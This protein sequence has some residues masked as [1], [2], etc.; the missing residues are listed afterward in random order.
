MIQPEEDFNTWILIACS[1]IDDPEQFSYFI[2]DIQRMIYSIIDYHSLPP[3]ITNETVTF[4][5]RLN[6]DILF[7]SLSISRMS[8]DLIELFRDLF[9]TVLDFAKYGIMVRNEHIIKCG[10]TLIQNHGFPIFRISDELSSIVI[11]DYAFKIELYQLSYKELAN[12]PENIGIFAAYYHIIDELSMND[13]SFYLIDFSTICARAALKLARENPR[14]NTQAISRIFTRIL[15]DITHDNYDTSEIIEFCLPWL[16]LFC[17]FAKSGIFEKVLFGFQ[18]IKELFDD[19]KLVEGVIDYF[20]TP[21]NLKIFEF[22]TIHPEL[23]QYV[24][25]I[26][27]YLADY[28]FVPIELLT[29]LWNL[30]SVQH[31]SDLSKFLVIFSSIATTLSIAKLNILVPLCISPAKENESEEWI[32]FLFIFGRNVG[33]RTEAE[34]CFELIRDKLLTLSF[35]PGPFQL[36]IQNKLPAII[37][38]H[39]N[40]ESFNSIY[41]KLKEH[42]NENPFFIYSL[43]SAAFFSQHFENR[44]EAEELLNKTFENLESINDES[45]QNVILTFIGS[46][47]YN[48]LLELE[49]EQL[50]IIF[51]YKNSK[52]FV[53]LVSRLILRDLIPIDHLQR[54]ILHIPPE[55]INDQI[56][57]LV[58]TI[59]KFYN[60]LGQDF[61]IRKLP[62]IH[63]KL[64]WE[65]SLK[66][67][68]QTENFAEFLCKLYSSNDGINLSDYDMMST[69]IQTWNEYFFGSSDKDIAISLLRNFIH[70]IESTI[71]VESYNIKRHTISVNQ[72]MIHVEINSNLL[73]SNLA[74]DLPENTLVLVV[75]HRVA[76]VAFITVNEFIFL[77][78]N[79]VVEARATLRQIAGNQNSLKFNIKMIMKDKVRPNRYDRKVI[80]SQLI[81]QS[82][83]T[84]NYLV[85]LL[86]DNNKEAKLLLDFLPTNVDTLIHIDEM[87]KRKSFDYSS[88]LP[89]EF[90]NLF[91]YNFEALI[92]KFNENVNQ[93]KN[94]FRRTGGFHYLIKAILNEELST[95]VI[96][97]MKKEMD[98]FIKRELS[99][100]LFDVLLPHLIKI[101]DNTSQF[102]AIIE[103]LKPIFSLENLNIQLPN[104]FANDILKP[105]IFSKYSINRKTIPEFLSHLNIPLSMFI[106]FIEFVTEE[107]ADTFYKAIFPH[108][109]EKNDLLL[110]K[111]TDGINT[112]PSYLYSLLSCLDKMLENNFINEDDKIIFTKALINSYLF[113]DSQDKDKECFKIAVH[114]L[115]M[116]QN[117]ILLDHLNRLHFGRTQYSEWDIDGDSNIVS[118]NGHCGLSNLGATCF[119]NS[120]LQQF[121]S[122]PVLRK[123]VIE[124]NGNDQFMNQLRILF[125]E[126]Y[127]S[128]GQLQSP[129]KLVE[130][131]T[132]WDGEPMDPLIQQDAV[133]FT[134][135]LIDKLESGLTREFMNDIFG[136][137][138]LDKF[139]GISDHF[140]SQSEQSFSSF[141]LPIQGSSNVDEAFLKYQNPDFFT[142]ENQYFAESLNKKIDAKKY[143][144]LGKLPRVLIMQLSRFEYDYRLGN[145]TK[146]NSTFHFPSMLDLS[147]YTTNDINQEHIYSIHG[148]VMHHGAADFGHYTSYIKDKETN[149]WFLYNDSS[150][151]EVNEYEVLLN[152]SGQQRKN[153]SGYILFYERIDT[154]NEKIETPSISLSLSSRIQQE[155]H[156]KDEYRLFCSEPYYELMKM[157]AEKGDFH[158]VSIPIYYYFDTFP[159]TLHVKKANDFAPLIIEKL[160]KFKEL[161]VIFM[162]FLS[163][164]PFSCSLIYSSV[165]SVRK[166]ALDMIKTLEFEL[167]TPKFIDKLIGQINSLY[168]Y[169]F[170]QYFLLIYHLISNSKIIYDYIVNKNIQY[171]IT[172]LLFQNIPNSILENNDNID[173]FYRGIC[174]TGLFYVISKIKIYPNNI[175]FFLNEEFM[176]NV[177]KSRTTLDSVNALLKSFH[178]LNLSNEAFSYNNNDY[179]CGLSSHQQVSNFIMNLAGKY[180]IY[181]N[182]FRIIH[183]LFYYYQIDA[184]PLISRS[185]FVIEGRSSNNFDLAMAICMLIQQST[186]KNIFLDNLDSWLFQLLTDE[187]H[188]CRIAAEHAISFLVQD[189]LFDDIPL[190]PMHELEYCDSEFSLAKLSNFEM[191]ERNNSMIEIASAVHKCLLKNKN[192][193]IELLKKCTDLICYQYID[194]FDI[195]SEI[196]NYDISQDFA[197]IAQEG[198]IDSN[199]IKEFD[200]HLS[201]ICKALK[202]CKNSLYL[203]NEFIYQFFPLVEQLYNPSCTLTV[204]IKFFREMENSVTK[205][206]KPFIEVFLKQYT[207]DDNINILGKAKELKSYLPIFAEN[208]PDF[209]FEILK[210]N[211]FKFATVNLSDVIYLLTM[212]KPDRK[213]PL[214]NY[215]WGSVNKKQSYPLNEMVVLAFKYHLHQSKPNEQSN[216]CINEF[217]DDDIDDILAM[218]SLLNSP[219][220]HES[221]RKC[222]WK[223]IFDCKPTFIEFISVYNW[224]GDWK[225]L[226]IYLMIE[227]SPDCVDLAIEASRNSL[228]A[229]EILFEFLIENAPEKIMTLSFI[230]AIMTQTMNYN[231]DFVIHFIKSLCII[232]NSKNNLQNLPITNDCPIK[233]DECAVNKESCMKNI[234]NHKENILEYDNEFL[235][236][237]ITPLADDL[238]LRVKCFNDI[239]V[240]PIFEAIDGIGIQQIIEKMKVLKEFEIGKKLCFKDIDLL[241]KACNE[242]ICDNLNLPEMKELLCLVQEF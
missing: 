23:C 42:G 166:G 64:L 51:K 176:I 26:L 24:S 100:E 147:K 89:L 172:K 96:A 127:L 137:T 120:T 239:L 173:S 161:R 78:F 207:F 182:Y 112:H 9:F 8:D 150:V 220:L 116:M 65:M 60:E 38:Y 185:R 143:A 37:N 61:R 50:D 122:I 170:D 134:Q 192:K 119:L 18:Q 177:L 189:R 93:I 22:K 110:S 113:P 99:Q 11:A 41:F 223:L 160:R 165:V 81:M 175:H 34:S 178:T 154:I 240:D 39:L 204:A 136:G 129:N 76:R 10:F 152:G 215:I 219:E 72:K 236:R 224:K 205:F 97:F 225:D 144:I 179:G 54:I 105:L 12:G 88:F 218:I 158:F 187:L 153:S 35:T 146:I 114:C 31:S 241:K 157:L 211:I 141:T 49:N 145:R 15:G 123:A 6:N 33:E 130:V 162:D 83:E 40:R 3:P 188:D 104:N 44:S 92:E 91:M 7:K 55:E 180:G 191:I 95:K 14:M 77:R 118:S 171:F 159:F 212:I 131:W 231:H 69:F 238:C 79:K 58:S 74:F 90:P 216:E 168:Y 149:K 186:L 103:F 5:I 217:T 56:Y 17:F 226:A 242:K 156:K 201:R 67:S 199:N 16:D 222:V 229:F 43:L 121:F 27:T 82:S 214:L 48:N 181:N 196:I 117:N 151:S 29:S 80:P 94:H 200:S 126:M 45:S 124:Y 86:K 53:N 237:I 21:E 190:L 19:E 66:R 47:C 32:N 233:T 1:T 164:G 202:R 203:N 20:S 135:M 98:D 138:T 128:K 111:I 235:E 30:H 70:E 68:S 210:Q 169:E 63:E 183:L 125:A 73:S 221:G 163:E 2:P 108:I 46:L 59:V 208:E 184:I 206:P 102:I 115:S 198:I 132:G 36:L 87:K 28:D 227:K 109:Y 57:Y 148:V 193:A 167:F 52:D 101:E 232:N 62:F 133:E 13:E 107:T 142:G 234:E 85:S 139:E 197:E 25:E 230:Q 194:S 195:L 75:K 155:N 84:V 174:F 140:I 106:D 228:E 4:I 209:V 213:L 71:D